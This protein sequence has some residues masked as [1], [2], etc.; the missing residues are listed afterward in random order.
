MNIEYENYLLEPEFRQF[1]LYKSIQ[2]KRKDGTLYDDTV[3]M[4][5]G[6]RFETCIEAI[7]K[8][9]MA[10]RNETIS[11]RKYI[12]EYNLLNDEILLNI[13]Q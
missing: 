12:Y 13:Q 2:R 9:K 4:G 6:M 5:Y 7:C 8:D 3:V 11:I 1:N 10:D